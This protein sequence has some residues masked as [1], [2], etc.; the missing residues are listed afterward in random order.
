VGDAALVQ[1]RERL[2]HGAQE[3][4]R[5]VDVQGTRARQARRERLAE[6]QLVR[7]VVAAVAAARLDAARKKFVFDLGD[8]AICREKPVQA[9]A[10]ARCL[11]PQHAQA[12]F[13]APAR[14]RIH[15]R[16]TAFA[17]LLR[18]RELAER[19]ADRQALVARAAFRADLRDFIAGVGPQRQHG[20]AE[21]FGRVLLVAVAREGSGERRFGGGASDLLRV[22]AQKVP[23]EVEEFLELERTLELGAQQFRL[24]HG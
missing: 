2:E 3:G 9:A 16:R 23:A 18:D 10:V 14:R 21:R 11:L 5:V 4:A 20:V 19:R 12:E 22:E 15:D 13:A 1:G 17:E 24:D 8:Q 7:D 6:H